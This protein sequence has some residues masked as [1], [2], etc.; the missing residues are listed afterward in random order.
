[1]SGTIAK[2]ESALF[3]MKLFLQNAR[4]LEL[5]FQGPVGMDAVLADISCHYQCF[6]DCQ[7]GES[8]APL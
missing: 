1:M 7:T 2:L 3:A 6:G 8:G 4:P 5:H